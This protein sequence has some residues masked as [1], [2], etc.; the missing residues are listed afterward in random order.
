MLCAFC[1]LR[2]DCPTSAYTKQP[3][4]NLTATCTQREFAIDCIIMFQLYVLP[5][6]FVCL[7]CFAVR[8]VIAPRRF[9]QNNQ[10]LIG[11]PHIHRESSS[12]IYFILVFQLYVSPLCSVCFMCIA[13][14][15]VIAP[16][17]L[18]QNNKCLIGRP[19]IHRESL[20]LIIFSCLNC[21]FC[22]CALFAL[23]VLLFAGWLPHVSWYNNNQCLIWR[24]HIHR[25]SLSLIAFSC[26]SCVFGHCALYALCV[27][28]F[29]GWLPHVCLYKTTCV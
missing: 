1:R 23:C 3:V 2:G 27:L 11:R 12:L 8:G 6:C 25:E 17:R 10:C 29:A 7:V 9:I 22:H 26:F 21:L 20:S 18:I 24:Q 14:H 4:L 28:P 5:L 15:R 13:V 16:R 19:H